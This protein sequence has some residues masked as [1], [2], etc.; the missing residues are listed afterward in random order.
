M[1]TGQCR[2]LSKLLPVLCQDNGTA[3]LVPDLVSDYLAEPLLVPANDLLD[4]KI[5]C[6]KFGIQRKGVALDKALMAISSDSP[7]PA[8]VLRAQL[9]VAAAS[10]RSTLQGAAV[11]T[12]VLADMYEV[13]QD[14]PTDGEVYLYSWFFEWEFGQ[15]LAADGTFAVLGELSQ[16]LGGRYMRLSGRD[17]SEG[18][19]TRPG[20]GAKERRESRETVKTN[21]LGGPR[22]EYPR[23]RKE[24]SAA[25]GRARRRDSSESPPRPECGGCGV[26][27][28]GERGGEISAGAA[29]IGDALSTLRPSAKQPVEKEEFNKEPR[30]GVVR[31]VRH[32]Q[33]PKKNPAL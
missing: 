33:E 24:P 23:N 1:G 18:I 13:A 2:R 28:P 14:A 4:V 22:A 12:A 10:D 26:D 32:P 11:Y 21:T 31:R 7:R 19:R 29:A 9:R 20:G 17:R 6:Y 27:D 5:Y 15:L 16:P 3:A 30:Q 8:S 25:G